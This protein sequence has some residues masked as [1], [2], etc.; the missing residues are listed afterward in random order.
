MLQRTSRTKMILSS[1]ATWM[2]LQKVC[3]KFNLCN[4]INRASS[5]VHTSYCAYATALSQ[6]GLYLNMPFLRIAFEKPITSNCAVN[7][8]LLMRKHDNVFTLKK[9]IFSKN[10]LTRLFTIL[11][12]LHAPGDCFRGKAGQV[13]PSFLNVWDKWV[14]YWAITT[15]SQ[16]YPLGIMTYNSRPLLNKG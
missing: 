3:L 2:K 15:K 11:R 8:K 10:K 5:G 6:V 9:K 14:F 16:N 12:Q 1:S 13:R 4:R 7:D